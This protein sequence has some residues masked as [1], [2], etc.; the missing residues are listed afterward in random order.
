MGC[1]AVLHH[2]FAVSALAVCIFA[3][4]GFAQTTGAGQRWETAQPA[5][6]AGQNHQGERTGDILHSGHVMAFRANLDDL[7]GERSSQ[8]VSDL[9]YSPQQESQAKFLSRPLPPKSDLPSSRNRDQNPRMA[10]NSLWKTTVALCGVLAIIVVLAR[11]LKKHGPVSVAG[12]PEEAIQVLGGRPLNRQHNIQLVRCGS[13]ILV[14]G[15][16]TD[17][18]TTLAEITD[19]LEIDLLTGLCRRKEDESSMSQAFRTL[20][21]K[22]AQTLPRSVRESRP[23]DPAVGERDLAA[24]THKK[25]LFQSISG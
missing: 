6:S 20:F 25:P 19:P 21:Q 9:Q 23:S 2:T 16:S 5:V 13:R 14:L 3:T 22:Q 4:S 17:S 7:N 8:T 11:V 18:I 24:E 15:I 10:T 12:I 1:H